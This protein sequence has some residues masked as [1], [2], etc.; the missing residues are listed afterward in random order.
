MRDDL[1]NPYL[2]FFTHKRRWTHRRALQFPILLRGT[3]QALIVALHR[4]LHTRAPA[5]G[6]CTREAPLL[7]PREVVR[8]TFFLKIQPPGEGPLCLF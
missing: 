6:G 7:A 8:R 5:G 1:E 4:A 3:S 2:F